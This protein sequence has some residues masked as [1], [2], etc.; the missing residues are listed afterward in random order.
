MKNKI[1]IILILI[2]FFV[3]SCNNKVCPA[4]SG[5]TSNGLY[6]NQKRLVK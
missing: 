1:I 2:A 4:Y 6:T 3:I 5:K